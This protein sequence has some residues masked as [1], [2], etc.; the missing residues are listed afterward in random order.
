MFHSLTTKQIPSCFRLLI[1]GVFYCIL[2]RNFHEKKMDVQTVG[3]QHSFTGRTSQVLAASLLEHLVKR[4]GGRQMKMSTTL[5]NAAKIFS[6]PGNPKSKHNF[7]HCRK[8]KKEKENQF[9]FSVEQPCPEH[10]SSKLCYCRFTVLKSFNYS[11]R[12]S[13]TYHIRI[14]SLYQIQ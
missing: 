10:L 7:P 1:T 11:T 6:G 3:K 12:I 9:N 4:K 2:F 5:S 13:Y 8:K 14:R